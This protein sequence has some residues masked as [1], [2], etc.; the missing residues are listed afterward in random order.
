MKV[1]K[2]L[3]KQ[4]VVSCQALE[5]EPLHSSYIMGR[6]AL[7]AKQGGAKGIRANS[8]EDIKEIQKQVDLP[9]IGI[10][11]QDYTDSPIYITPTVK[12]VDTLLETGCEIIAIDATKRIRPNDE[13]LEDII[14]FAK[15]KRP[16]V[17]LMADI[18][19]LE[20]A[21]WADELGFDCISTTL[22]GYTD[23]SAGNNIYDNDFALLKEI[24]AA[25][26]KPVIAEG[27]IDTPE[28][29]LKALQNG[30]NFVVV[31]SAITRPQLITKTFADA[32]SKL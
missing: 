28:K 6:M 5:N 25:V 16:D 8:V 11:K 31:G 4:L 17:A 13:K 23:E 24:K 3:D 26:S 12:E 10:I 2:Q 9:I 1:F 19:T 15:E 32:V 29:A 30:A 21:I 22:V 27:K 14:R 7:A 18:S 20:E